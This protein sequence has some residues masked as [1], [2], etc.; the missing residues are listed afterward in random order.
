MMQKFE[1]FTELHDAVAREHGFV[2][3]RAFDAGDA[4]TDACSEFWNNN[5][6]WEW[7]RNGC[8]IY[9]VDSDGTIRRHV[10]GPPDFTPEFYADDGE[11]VT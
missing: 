11:V 5:D 9:S 7:M 2:V 8:T 3:E 1:V 4:A 10:V 6:G